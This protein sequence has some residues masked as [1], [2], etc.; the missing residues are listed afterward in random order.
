V[1]N[2]IQHLELRDRATMSQT[3]WL[4]SRS[5]FKWVVVALFVAWIFIDWTS[6]KSGELCKLRLREIHSLVWSHRGHVEPYIDAS[7]EAT[8]YLTNIGVHHFDVDVVFVREESGYCTFYVSHPSR[9]IASNREK[10][11][12]V[13]T[14]LDYM[15]SEVSDGDVQVT[16][17]PKWDDERV[18]TTFVQLVNDH[19]FAAKCAIIVRLKSEVVLLELYGPKLAVAIPL[20]STGVKPGELWNPIQMEITYWTQKN[21]IVLMP[22]VKLLSLYPSLIQSFPKYASLVFWIVDDFETLKHVLQRTTGEGR[23]VSYISNQPELLLK[24][25]LEIYQSECNNVAL[26]NS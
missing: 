23:R 13:T 19:T 6:I 25:L 22:D 1:L 3:H 15:L 10:Y 17:E 4:L 14:F 5:W 7:R 2:V 26:Y 24:L 9:F 21:R 16:M 11:T 18:L 8:N 20:R 12:T